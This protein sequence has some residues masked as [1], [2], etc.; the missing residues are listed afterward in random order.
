MH[1][2][3]NASGLVNSRIQPS[4]AVGCY[5]WICHVAWKQTAALRRR[6]WNTIWLNP[7]KSGLSHKYREC[8]HSC[9]ARLCFQAFRLFLRLSMK[10]IRQ[11]HRTSC[12][13]AC[14]AMLSDTTYTETMTVAAVIF[15]WSE[16]QRSF[17]TSSSQLQS[18]LFE[19][20]VPAQ[21]GRSI[22]RWSSMPDIAIAGINHNE[23]SDTWHWVIFRRESGREYVLDPQSKREVRTDFGRMRLRS[24]IPIKLATP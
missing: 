9:T 4:P 16:S 20:K 13:I 14:V 12:G 11:E 7:A 1:S 5:V 21:K 23:K 17:Y 6:S 15:K 19:M 10:R 18:L 2:T 24:C 8:R 3:R 22:R